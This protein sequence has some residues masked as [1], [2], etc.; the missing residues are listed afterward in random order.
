MKIY[1]K[2]DNTCAALIEYFLYDKELP[3]AIKSLKKEINNY[4]Y[5]LDEKILCRIM[6]DNNNRNQTSIVP[7]LPLILEI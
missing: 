4:Y 5:D 7:V 3:D 2:K 1:Q 6:T